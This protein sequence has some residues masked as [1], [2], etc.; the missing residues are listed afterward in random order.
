[1]K[2][3]EEILKKHYSK[4]LPNH[5]KYRTRKDYFSAMDEYAFLREVKYK[6]LIEA[7]KEYAKLLGESE[8]NLAIFADTHGIKVDPKIVKRG[9]ELRQKIILIEQEL[10]LTK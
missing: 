3:K 9:K 8:G 7:W 10:G 2:T 1:M 5:S 6:K 4:I